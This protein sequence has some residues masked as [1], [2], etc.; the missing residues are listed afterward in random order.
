M[1]IYEGIEIHTEAI[2]G[3]TLSFN[4]LQI[5][6]IFLC[7]YLFSFIIQTLHNRISFLIKI[8]IFWIQSF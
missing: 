5:I 7:Y 1:Q 4:S 6:Y 8:Y 3:K 2:T